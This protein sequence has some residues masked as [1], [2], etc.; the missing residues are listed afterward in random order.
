MSWTGFFSIADLSRRFGVN[1]ETLRARLVRWRR[2]NPDSLDCIE[3]KEAHVNQPRLYFRVAAIWGILAE[4]GASA[5]YLRRTE[6]E[7]SANV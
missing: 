5:E 7:D 3:D 6:R 1:A 2:E 4:L